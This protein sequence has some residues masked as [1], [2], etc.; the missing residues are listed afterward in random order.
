MNETLLI[1]DLVEKVE[2][3]GIRLD[4]QHVQL[5]A[6]KRKVEQLEGGAK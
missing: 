3:M 1:R 5:E 4:E 6:L 2:R